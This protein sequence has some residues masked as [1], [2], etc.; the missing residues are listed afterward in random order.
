[1][2]EA[3]SGMP[4]RRANVVKGSV[5]GPRSLPRAPPI[6]PSPRHPSLRR[7]L[8]VLSAAVC[9]PP[10]PP[11]SAC[12]PVCCCRPPLLLPAFPVRLPPLGRRQ[13]R[14]GVNSDPGISGAPDDPFQIYEGQ[15]WTKIR[16]TGPKARKKPRHTEI[17]EDLRRFTYIHVDRRRYT[18]MYVN[19]HGSTCISI[20]LCR[21]PSICVYKHRSVS[22]AELWQ[23]LHPQRY[24]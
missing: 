24:M 7:R 1:M 5:G 17:H 4:M 19:Q 13:W 18:W 2:I 6:G 16:F 15:R 21:Y 20:C 9:L 14:G 3:L 22:I 8:P 10:V 12:C 11:P 23:Q